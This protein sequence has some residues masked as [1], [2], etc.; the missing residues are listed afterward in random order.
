M[1]LI[2][3][4]EKEIF[5]IPMRLGARTTFRPEALFGS[6]LVLTEFLAECLVWFGSS[7]R[8]SGRYD[9]FPI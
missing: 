4:Q 3:N 7:D 9:A 8:V 6:D 2:L 1:K 5:E